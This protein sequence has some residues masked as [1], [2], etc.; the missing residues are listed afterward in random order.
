VSESISAK[1]AFDQIV[2][3]DKNWA[4]AVRAFDDYPTRLRTLADA[5]DQRSRALMLAH[6][7]K[8]T[9]KPRPN[10][11][12]ATLASG[13][14]PTSKRPGPPAMWR[15]F[16]QAIQDIGLALEDGNLPGLANAFSQF[17]PIANELADAC[18][19]ELTPKRSKAS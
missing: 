12:V 11:S 2:E 7:A 17:V 3:T 8:I 18:E 15:R 6:L 9:G 13:L 19:L 14:D 16:D 5:A 10:A 4:S 1:R